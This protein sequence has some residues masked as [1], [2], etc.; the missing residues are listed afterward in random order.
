[1]STIRQTEAN[2]RNAQQSTGPTSVT[3]KAASSMNALKT[4]IHANSL[5]LPSED[6][7]DLEQ[8]TGEYYQHHRPTSPEARLFVDEL[9]HCEWNLRRLRAA[10]TQLRQYQHGKYAHPAVDLPLGDACSCDP[11]V[12]SQLQWRIDSTRR[13]YHR[14]L[15]ALQELQ[16]EAEAAPALAPADEPDPSAIDSPALIPSPRNTSLQIGFVPTTP[17]PAPNPGPS[18]PE[19]IGT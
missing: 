13:A 10:E 2:R 12:F 19:A 16:A 18:G 3:G 14:A 17:I 5:V 11:R 6:Q 4:G 8:L 1:M 7:A 9:V 15:Q